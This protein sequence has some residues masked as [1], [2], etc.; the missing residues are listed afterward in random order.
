MIMLQLTEAQASRIAYAM[1]REAAEYSLQI[2]N[3]RRHGALTI[4]SGRNEVIAINGRDEC[5]AIAKAID[6]ALV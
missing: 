2:N 3:I 1:Q 4:A 5:L 6:I